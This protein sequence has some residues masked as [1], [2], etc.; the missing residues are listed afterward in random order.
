MNNENEALWTKSFVITIIHV[1]IIGFLFLL[2]L[3]IH[4]ILSKYRFDYRN[5]AIAQFGIMFVLGVDAMYLV[6]ARQNDPKV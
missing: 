6:A 3:D 1:A 2:T 4:D 5:I